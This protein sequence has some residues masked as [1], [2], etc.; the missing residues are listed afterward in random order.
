M[1]N[2]GQVYAI[3]YALVVAGIGVY[4]IYYGI[5]EHRRMQDRLKWVEEMR[6]KY[7]WLRQS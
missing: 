7:P 5:K 1:M 6:V 2:F 3:I 4:L